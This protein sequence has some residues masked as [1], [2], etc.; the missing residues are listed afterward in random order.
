M[1]D[2][3]KYLTV[4]IKPSFVGGIRC[5]EVQ[6]A[7][8]H[9]GQLGWELVNLVMPAPMNPVVLIFKQPG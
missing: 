9:H 6:Q 2:R 1:P 4:E 8:D 5:D 3:W 7:L